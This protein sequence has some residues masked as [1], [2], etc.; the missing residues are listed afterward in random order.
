MAGATHNVTQ[1]LDAWSNGDS[2]ALDKL[3]PLVYSELRH[4]AQSY[5]RQE[6]PGHTLQPSALVN[7]AYLRLVDQSVPDWRNRSHFFGVA[8]KLMRDILVDHARRHRATK[9]HGGRK[10]TLDEAMAKSEDRTADLI[11]LDDALTE[12]QSFDPRKAKMVELR[13]FVGLSVE[14]TARALDVSVATVHRN[15]K[16]AETWLYRKLHP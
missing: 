10:V 15:I 13:F 9:R 16:V 11:A 7:E 1:L 5:L 14:E 6:R 8:A 4:L 2:T 3:L 12:L